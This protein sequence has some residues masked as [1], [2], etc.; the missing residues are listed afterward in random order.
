MPVAQDASAT[1]IGG[2]KANPAR[3]LQSPSFTGALGAYGVEVAIDGRRPPRLSRRAPVAAIGRE[4]EVSSV[5]RSHVCPPH[6][7]AF[8]T[9]WLGSRNP[10]GLPPFRGIDAG[11]RCSRSD[12]G[13]TQVAGLEP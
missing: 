10:F 13:L 2:S 4:R 11:K 12:G 5:A 6:R 7:V 8:M 1:H 9:I 3:G